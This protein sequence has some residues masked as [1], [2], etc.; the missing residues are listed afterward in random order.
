MKIKLTSLILTLLYMGWN[1]G[2]RSPHS[3]EEGSMA[4]ATP[5][6]LGKNQL[7][8]KPQDAADLVGAIEDA[9]KK[10]VI[11][12]PS[13]GVDPMGPAPSNT[14]GQLWSKGILN[15]ERF[16]P[17]TNINGNYTGIVFWVGQTPIEISVK[18]EREMNNHPLFRVINAYKNQTQRIANSDWIG[19]N[20]KVRCTKP[21]KPVKAPVSCDMA[22]R[23]AG[24]A[25]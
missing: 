11:V 1:I 7:T 23:F 12:K 16:A 6:D 4:L 5:E 13:V 14:E 18:N 10:R 17:K 24:G 22:W 3:S 20:L 2:C 8:L 15:A 19:L 25:I 9:W 21:D